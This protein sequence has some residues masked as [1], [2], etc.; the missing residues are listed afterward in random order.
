[1]SGD[2]HFGVLDELLKV[3]RGEVID[4]L[5]SQTKRIVA[6][7]VRTA[8]NDLERLLFERC[9]DVGPSPSPPRIDI[10]LRLKGTE[11][12]I[13]D[14]LST[15]ESA[16]ESLRSPVAPEQ[17]RSVLRVTT[18]IVLAG[19]YST[20]TGP[21]A[22][23]PPRLGSNVISELISLS[24]GIGREHL[25]SVNRSVMSAL[26]EY[27]SETPDNLAMAKEVEVGRIGRCIGLKTIRAATF[28]SDIFGAVAF[29]AIPQMAELM[30]A[31]SA[32]QC[33]AAF[34]VGRAILAASTY[35]E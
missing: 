11:T 26:L 9:V 2:S 29:Q 34:G 7:F 35:T 17:T 31:I 19:E 28:V 14:V 5:P 22:S 12:L 32:D 27:G 18:L 33:N 6:A 1:M 3:S 8:A 20:I 15:L 10:G 24:H 30:P 16:H 13:S 4:D 23:A 21:T 25:P